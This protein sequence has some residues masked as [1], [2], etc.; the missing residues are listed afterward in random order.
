MSQSLKQTIL[1][2][3]YDEL[4]SEWNEIN[5]RTITYKKVPLNRT[6]GETRVYW[7]EELKTTHKTKKEANEAHR[8][9]KLKDGHR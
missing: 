8:R 9:A 7:D 2:S 1:D 5:A 3:M 4:M 6:P